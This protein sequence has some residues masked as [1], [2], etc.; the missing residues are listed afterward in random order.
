MLIGA[1]WAC[2]VYFSC[3]F[4][5]VSSVMSAVITP[6]LLIGTVLFSLPEYI[7]KIYNYTYILLGKLNERFAL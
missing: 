4:L 1:E 7:K 3:S 6:H 2:H 5:R